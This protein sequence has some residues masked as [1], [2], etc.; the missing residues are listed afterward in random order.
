MDMTNVLHQ[1]TLLFLLML[2]GFLC[3]KAGAIEEN[4]D[5]VFAS[6]VVNITLPA[7]IIGASTSSNIYFDG[8]TVLLYASVSGMI[9]VLALGVGRVFTK[10][11]CVASKDAGLYRFMLAFSNTGFIGYP[12][13]ALCLARNRLCL[14]RY[15]IFLLTF[16][17]IRSAFTSSQKE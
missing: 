3:R 13:M 10:V 12:I 16:L 2:V 9:Y 5:A 4:A 15:F 8:T 6:F 17:F 7:S 1:M 14:F 11:F